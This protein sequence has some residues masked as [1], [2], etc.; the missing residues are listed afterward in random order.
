MD[1][2]NAALRN[3]NFQSGGGDGQRPN[4][5]FGSRGGRGGGRSNFSRDGADGGANRSGGGA[6][7][8]YSG[9]SLGAPSYT[10]DFRTQRFA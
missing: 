8:S 10:R 5:R 4:G 6:G 3:N 7:G 9:S 2:I 1:A